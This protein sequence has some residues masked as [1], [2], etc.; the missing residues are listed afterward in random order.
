LECCTLDSDGDYT[1]LFGNPA[2]QKGAAIEYWK[3]RKIVIPTLL[4]ANWVL[5][6]FN[7]IRA[8]MDGKKTN[9]V[10]KQL[11]RF[12]GS[13]GYRED[14]FTKA[15]RARSAY[16]HCAFKN[17]LEGL[18]PNAN[19]TTRDLGGFGS[20]V[21]GHSNTDVNT[22]SS[23]KCAVLVPNANGEIITKL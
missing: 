10:T 2:K 1:L 14:G 4:P 12:L 5:E 17:N 20:C 15:Y 23:Y 6:G 21:L 8:N 11:E 19:L 7:Y 3:D 13:K 9:T 16:L 22:V 18:Y